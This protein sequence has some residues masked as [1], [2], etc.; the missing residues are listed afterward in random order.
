[1]KEKP[2]SSKGPRPLGIADFMNFVNDTEPE[3]TLLAVKAPIEQAAGAFAD[4]R[5]TDRWLHDVPRRDSKEDDDLDTSLAM[6]LQLRDSP[7]TVIIRDLFDYTEP[8]H[9]GIA[10]DARTLSAKFKTRAIAFS[11][12]DTAG[13][14]AYD[15]F[16]GGQL[17]ERA[18]W[19][20]GG[21]FFVFR[22][23]LRKQPTI[24]EVG[25]EFADEVFR[26]QGIYVP[27]CYAKSEEEDAWICVEKVSADSI[28][29][30]DLIGLEQPEEDE[31]E[32]EEDDEDEDEE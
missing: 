3:W 6:A 11:G 12:E 30:A 24:N 1:M 10:Q 18:E 23:T 25:Q 13:V 20:E 31:D 22:S 15:L 26:E 17:L 32:D 16:D 28:E 21:E 9:K 19:E 5:K 14:L 4:L 2:D 7:W 29:R 27:A 8:G